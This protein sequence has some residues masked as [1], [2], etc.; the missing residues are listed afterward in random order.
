MTD[1]ENA[2]ITRFIRD[3][4]VRLV[5]EPCDRA[6]AILDGVAN[7]LERADLERRDISS[8]IADEL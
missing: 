2:V 4:A 3:N 7:F 5:N 1:E 8:H 6:R